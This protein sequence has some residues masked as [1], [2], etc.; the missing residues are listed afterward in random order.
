MQVDVTSIGPGIPQ[1]QA[2]TNVLMEEANL[3][4][5]SRQERD[6]Y[7]KLKPCKF[8]LTNVYDPRLLQATGMDAELDLIFQ[9]VGWEGFW[10]VSE[11]G[12]RLLTME[13]L[14][15]LKITDTGVDFRFFGKEYSSSWKDLSLLLGFDA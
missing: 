14:C 7:K 8:S 13:F 12:S 1:E 6:N 5:Q 11:V 4:W 3:R 15:T 2:T 9:V 10:D